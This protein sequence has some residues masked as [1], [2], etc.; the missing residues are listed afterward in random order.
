MRKILKYAVAGTLESSDI[1]ITLAPVNEGS[2]V[3]VDLSS[4]VDMYYH[5]TIMGVIKSTLSELLVSDVEVTAVDHGALDCTIK[6][7][8]STAVRRAQKEI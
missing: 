3:R 1:M 5:D 4:T 7:R 2:G 8:V 6:A